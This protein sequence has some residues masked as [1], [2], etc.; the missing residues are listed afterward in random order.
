M[1]TAAEEARP[2]LVLPEY[3]PTGPELVRRRLGRH[4]RR[5][6]LAV[7]ALV[8]V[9]LAVLIVTGAGDG[10]AKLEHRTAPQ[11]TLLLPGRRGPSG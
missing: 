2:G 9:G 5:I 3:G 4:G 10:L 8:V 11:F 7:A 1:A 6:V